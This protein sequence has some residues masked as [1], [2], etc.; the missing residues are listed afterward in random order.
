VYEFIVSFRSL[1]NLAVVC[2]Q[3]LFSLVTVKWWLL[4]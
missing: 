2:Q 1:I 4:M 3:F